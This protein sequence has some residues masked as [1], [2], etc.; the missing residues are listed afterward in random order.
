LDNTDLEMLREDN[1]RINELEKQMKEV[2]IKVNIEFPD[3][4]KKIFSILDLKAN[5]DDLEQSKAKIISI[6]TLILDN[7][8][9]Q[10]ANLKEAIDQINSDL[11][12]IQEITIIKRKIENIMQILGNLKHSNTDESEAKISKPIMHIENKYVEISIYNEFLKNNKLQ[13][14]NINARID[15]LRKLIDDILLELKNKVNEKDLKNLEGNHP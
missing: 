10:I 12:D 14:D 8:E 4:F 7:F 9:F 3:L 1:K 15:E 11:K 2:F 5:L 13:I 6:F